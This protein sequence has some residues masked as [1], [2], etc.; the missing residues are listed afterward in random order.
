MGARRIV[1]HAGG[2]RRSNW[3]IDE[4]RPYA[5]EPAAWGDM[6]ADL[7]DGDDAPPYARGDWARPQARAFERPPAPY[8]VL[9]VGAST[10]LKQWPIERWSALADALSARG[11]RVVW[12]AGRGEESIVA[13]CD[14][15]RR[16]AS[17][18]GALDLA[19]L[20]ELLEG[21]ALLVAPD[22]GVSHLGRVAWTPT[23]A[24]FGPG[25]AAVCDRGRF[26]RDT[27]WHAVGAATFPCRDQRMLFGREI[28]WVRRCTR[29]TAECAEPRCMQAI[30]VDAVLA[31]IDAM[32]P[33]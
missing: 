20:W 31:A 9:H 14:P 27:P 17:L 6:V 5:D 3:P 1:A 13:A 18:A 21:A 32:L 25:S 12:S 28:A 23:V 26:W 29:S 2:R 30:S 4:L 10:P 8:A 7:V 11:L 33:A 22:T 24:L 15:A 16:H 19:Q